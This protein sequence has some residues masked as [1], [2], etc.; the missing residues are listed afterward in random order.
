MMKLGS[1]SMLC[2]GGSASLVSQ[3]PIISFL[4]AELA[5]DFSIFFCIYTYIPQ[6]APAA[7]VLTRFFLF[8]RARVLIGSEAGDDPAACDDG[9]DRD[10]GV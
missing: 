3:F 10:N 2:Q 1:K 9:R 7:G 8:G 6:T 4:H 5:R